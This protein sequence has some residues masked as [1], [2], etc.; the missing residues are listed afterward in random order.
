M[1]RIYGACPCDEHAALTGIH[2]MRQSG[3]FLPLN[4]LAGDVVLYDI[5]RVFDVF[6]FV[7]GFH[8]NHAQTFRIFHRAK[9]ER[10]ALPRKQG[11]GF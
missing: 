3:Q 2:V 5:A 8:D 4:G 9:N 7:N 1:R 11:F 6:R 10:L